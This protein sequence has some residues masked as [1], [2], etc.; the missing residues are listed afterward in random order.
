[1]S[2]LREAVV[3]P[4]V[5]LTV[6]LLGGLRVTADGVRLLPPALDA[7]TLAMLLVAALARAGVFVPDFLMNARRAAVE[8]LNGLVVLLALFAASA[9]TFNLL[10]PERGLLRIIFSVFFFVQLMTT[11]AAA[12]SRRAMLRGLLV[13]FGAAF[14]L[15]FIVLESLYSVESRFL[16]RILTAALEGVTLGALDYD[17]NAAATG[18]AAFVALTAFMAGLT[19]LAPLSHPLH[20]NGSSGL[21]PSSS[22]ADAYLP[23]DGGAVDRLQRPGSAESPEGER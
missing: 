21:L 13:L 9:Q 6:A 1:M 19:L 16:R 22:A 4:G 15:R 17:P 18:Y 7:L 5:F 3:L 12:T 14:I 8:N 23:G 2:A 20:R 11:L 10:T